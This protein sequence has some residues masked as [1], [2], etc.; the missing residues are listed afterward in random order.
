MRLNKITRFKPGQQAEEIRQLR[1]RLSHA[2]R[3]PSN[4]EAVNTQAKLL[5][6]EL[7]LEGFRKQFHE[8]KDMTT[9]NKSK[10]KKPLMSL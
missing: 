10:S 2:S 3:D 5:A 9:A 4:V 1:A 7:K 6:I 8:F